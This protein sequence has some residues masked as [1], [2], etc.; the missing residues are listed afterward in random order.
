MEPGDK[1]GA[2]KKK[3]GQHIRPPRRGEAAGCTVTAKS[4]GRK[5][6][7]RRVGNS[8]RGKGVAGYGRGRVLM[9]EKR[10]SAHYTKQEQQKKKG[11]QE[12]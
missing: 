4:S 12:S 5:R 10:Q 7:K 8:P 1:E 11:H 2:R 9:D 6:K 3:M